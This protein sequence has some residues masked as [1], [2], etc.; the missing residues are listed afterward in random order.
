MR[1]YVRVTCPYCHSPFEPL[2]KAR[3]RCPACGRMVRVRTGPNGRRDIVRDEEPASRKRPR[4][5]VRE[6]TA[7]QRQAA[8]FTD[9]SGFETF[10]RQL[11]AWGMDSSPRE[12]FW[13]AAVDWLVKI[14]GGGDW[15]SIREAYA[16]LALAARDAADGADALKRAV[17]LLREANRAHLRHLISQGAD[18]VEIQADGCQLCRRHHAVKFV[19]LAELDHPRLPHVDCMDGW[20]SCEYK[21]SLRVMAIRWPAK[22]PRAG[23]SAE[24]ALPPTPSPTIPV[25]IESTMFRLKPVGPGRTETPGEPDV[26]G[27]PHCAESRARGARF[28]RACG[29]PLVEPTTLARSL[30]TPFR[31]R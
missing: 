19:A 18:R 3:K 11:S 17:E 4:A 29:R 6:R 10:E 2:P 30:K 21:A 9:A 8:P 12:V 26:L 16:V 14:L 1:E 23:P 28:C 7:W 15:P 25:P 22:P 20:C 5:P 13:T 24:S 27:C 31:G